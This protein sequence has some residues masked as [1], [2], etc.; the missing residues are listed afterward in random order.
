[1]FP[2][3]DPDEYPGDTPEWSACAIGTEQTAAD[4]NLEHCG[5]ETI[6]NQEYEEIEQKLLQ[7]CADRR[8]VVAHATRINEC[9]TREI[10][11]ISHE[12][13]KTVGE[14]EQHTREMLRVL[15]ELGGALQRTHG[16]AVG[17][18]GSEEGI[19]ETDVG[20]EGPDEIARGDEPG[21]P[22]STPG[23]RGAGANITPLKQLVDEAMTLVRQK[24]AKEITPTAVPQK[25]KTIEVDLLEIY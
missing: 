17:A 15:E 7:R 21:I 19:E 3:I 8:R 20:R 16:L 2:S 23:D 10:D 13:G 22:P 5:N 4:E 6:K 18:D 11:G 1:M 14:C 25:P 9:L 24:L 12:S